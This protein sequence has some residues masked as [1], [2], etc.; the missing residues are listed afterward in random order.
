[1]PSYLKTGGLRVYT[2][3]DLNVA[4][5]DPKGVEAGLLSASQLDIFCSDSSWN[6]SFRGNQLGL[7]R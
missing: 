6:G 3:R 1:M 4:P 5:S 7:V 2:S